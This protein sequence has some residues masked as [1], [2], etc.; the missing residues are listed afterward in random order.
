MHEHM[1]S[2]LSHELSVRDPQTIYIGMNSDPYQPAEESHQQTRKALALLAQRGFSACL[3]TKSDLVVRDVELLVRMKGSS[4]GISIAF[5]DDDVRRT[6]ALKRLK[7]AGVETYTLICPVMPFITD[8]ESLIEMVAQY[9]DT[10]RIYR[11]SMEDDQDRN[12][13]NV[14]GILDHDFPELTEQYRRIAFSGD[15]CYWIE[16]RARLEQVQLDRRLN[17]RIEL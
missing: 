1:V 10:I 8:V 13:Q 6:E 11:L 4:A 7:E 5:Q 2:R 3:L 9:S 16:L 17:L 15:H 14:R 12:W